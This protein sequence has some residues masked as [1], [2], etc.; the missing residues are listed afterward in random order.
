LNAE[1]LAG[2]ALPR[3]LG[4]SLA[5]VAGASWVVWRSAAAMARTSRSMSAMLSIS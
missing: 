4:A 2:V 1:L 3:L 5:V